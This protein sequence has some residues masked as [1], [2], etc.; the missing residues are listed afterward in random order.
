MRVVALDHTPLVEG[1]I[2]EGA[3]EHGLHAFDERWRAGRPR[4]R[5]VDEKAFLGAVMPFLSGPPDIKHY[6]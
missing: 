3:R 5:R 4:E 6:Q 2:P 1:H